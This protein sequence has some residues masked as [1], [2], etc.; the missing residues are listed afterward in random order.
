MFEGWERSYYLRARV[1]VSEEREVDRWRGQ[2]RQRKKLR[3]EAKGKEDA[4]NGTRKGGMTFNN[5]GALAK[6]ENKRPK[7]LTFG[8]RLTILP[9]PFMR[10]SAETTPAMR[11]PSISRLLFRSTAALSSKRTGSGYVITG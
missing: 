8:A 2:K 3:D 1:L 10:R 7:E 9:H 4:G 11:V 5:K 6:A